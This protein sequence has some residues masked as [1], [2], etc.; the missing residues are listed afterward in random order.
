MGVLAA[1]AKTQRQEFPGVARSQ[2]AVVSVWALHGGRRRGLRRLQLLAERRH[3]RCRRRQA[4]DQWALRTRGAARLV[5][6]FRQPGRLRPS[7]AAIAGMRHAFDGMGADGLA[8][9]LSTLLIGGQLA[10]MRVAMGVARGAMARWREV[11]WRRQRCKELSITCLQLLQ[12]RQAE[13]HVHC[14]LGWRVWA[15]WRREKHRLAL[16]AEAHLVN[17]Y[18]APAFRVWE[19]HTREKL[20]EIWQD[21]PGLAHGRPGMSRTRRALFQEAA[22]SRADLGSAP[23]MD[24]AWW[25]MGEEASASEDG[26][27]M[28]GPEDEEEATP[29][30]AGGIECA[31]HSTRQEIRQERRMRVLGRMA[32]ATVAWQHYSSAILGRV[33]TYWWHVSQMRVQ[34]VN[35]AVALMT[36]VA[37]MR[38]TGDLL[39][40]RT[41]MLHSLSFSWWAEYA[42]QKKCQRLSTQRGLEYWRDHRVT[43]NFIGWRK[44]HVK[45]RQIRV[46][47]TFAIKS[48]KREKKNAYFREWTGYHRQQRQLS[49]AGTSFS[50]GPWVAEPLLRAIFFR[51]PW[52]AEPLLR[53][54]FSPGPW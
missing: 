40:R 15:C 28:R 6:A 14:M 2:A 30:A 23:A 35:Q 21:S 7:A 18:L 22:E 44:W 20:S 34:R 37:E 25:P 46:R 53:A 3:C 43:I 12:R 17:T 48:M 33:I 27:S 52:V 9:D 51:G 24:E 16:C 38:V 29:G 31:D 42:M 50:P 5:H 36:A 19:R 8:G 47:V 10:A 4:L 49:V 11:V 32:T 26:G 13:L 54:I 41:Q 45:N 39:S 1:W